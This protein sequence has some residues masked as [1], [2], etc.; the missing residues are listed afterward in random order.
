MR[1]ARIEAPPLVAVAHGSKDPRAAAATEGLLAVVRARAAA[2]GLG[3]VDVRTA[4]LDHAAPSL[5]RVLGSL[6]PD[7]SR[8]VVVPLLLAPAY[9]A[10]ADIPGQTAKI[11]S[12]CP[13]LDIALA[14]T[15]GPHPGLLEA[16]DR[17]LEE[18][19]PGPRNDTSVVLAAAGSSDPAA[20]AANAALSGRL[21]DLGGW[22]RVVTAYASAA[23]PAPAEAVA[24]LRGD[25]P[26]IVGTYLLAPGYFA[27]KIRDTSLAAGAAAVSAPLGAAPEVA[28][29]IIGRYRDQDRKSLIFRTDHR[30][31]PVTCVPHTG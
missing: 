4:F 7:H 28:D 20:N 2:Q 30:V 8:C 16:L 1:P 25:G 3:G 23:S 27:D 9:H 22:R 21:R 17:R 12:A 29:V 19:W 26:V 14:D 6:A 13:G 15:V 18:C 11:R 10:K 24:E 5:P 31:S